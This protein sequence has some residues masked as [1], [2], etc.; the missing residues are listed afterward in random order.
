MEIGFVHV[1]ASPAIL[2]QV[3]VNHLS[4]FEQAQASQSLVGLC[5]YAGFIFD[6]RMAKNIFS[7]LGLNCVKSI[8]A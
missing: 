1:S 5:D 4:V 8:R 7:R 3:D 2:Q 6:Y